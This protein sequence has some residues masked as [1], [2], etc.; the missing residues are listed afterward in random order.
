[1]NE[2]GFKSLKAFMYLILFLE[3][4]VFGL[5]VEFLVVCL[6]GTNALFWTWENR[7]VWMAHLGTTVFGW[8]TAERGLWTLLWTAIAF[9]ILCLM[10]NICDYSKLE[11]VKD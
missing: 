2:N 10:N 3:A 7:N 5:I 1:M 6:R 4:C 9:L 11:E 8:T